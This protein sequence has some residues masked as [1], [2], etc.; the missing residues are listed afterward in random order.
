MGYPDVPFGHRPA[1]TGS[2]SSPTGVGLPMGV[3]M[4]AVPALR[5]RAAEGML[6]AMVD[7][8]DDTLERFVV[9]HYGCDT[10]RHERRNAVAIAFDG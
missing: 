6:Q 5:G 4:P 7:P 2:V 3:S 10:V 1:R 9:W 8:D